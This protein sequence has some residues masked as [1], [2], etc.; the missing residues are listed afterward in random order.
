[1]IDAEEDDSP[2]IIWCRFTQDILNVFEAL[3]GVGHC[4]PYHGGV[5]PK[6]RK[7][8]ID[9][10]LYQRNH[11]RFLIATPSSGGTGLNLQG[12]CTRAIYYSNSFNAIDRWQSEDRIHRIGTKGVVTYVDLICRGTID[13]SIL[14]NLRN[15]KDLS[16]L[17]LDQIRSVLVPGVDDAFDFSGS[18]E[19]ATFGLSKKRWIT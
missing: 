3:G 18:H 16:A 10:W 9:S 19:K 2:V 6:A 17:T 12:A 5:T 1:M 11:Q 15:K 7:E 14:G 4:L 8:S 13:A